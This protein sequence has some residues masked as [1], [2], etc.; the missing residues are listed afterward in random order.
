MSIQIEPTPSRRDAPHARTRSVRSTPR[1]LLWT[2]LAGIA[3]LV[4]GAGLL[5]AATLVTQEV[6]TARRTFDVARVDSLYI[7]SLAG[8]VEVVV[9]ERADIAVDSRLSSALG[10]EVA[11]T[12]GVSGRSLVIASRCD[13]RL[14]ATRCAASHT[15]AIPSDVAIDL[16]LETTAGDITVDGFSGET[17]TIETTAGNI[18]FDTSRAP[19]RLESRTAAGDIRLTVPDEVYRVA[20]GSTIGEAEVEVRHDR[21]ADRVI[22]A[23]TTVGRILVARR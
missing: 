8:D 7:S 10:Y 23:E 17:A 13:L 19:R 20:T 11:S 5:Y 4:L 6:S 16:E 1:R 3:A 14:F 12:A 2:G 15:V 21:D 9:E 22:S 18:V